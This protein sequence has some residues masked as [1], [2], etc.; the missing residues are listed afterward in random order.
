M[1][2]VGMARSVCLSASGRRRCGRSQTSRHGHGTLALHVSRANNQLG[3]RIQV[4]ECLNGYS[5][6]RCLIGIECAE[7]AD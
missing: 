7:I 5:A 6:L 2:V 3:V 1:S 4:V